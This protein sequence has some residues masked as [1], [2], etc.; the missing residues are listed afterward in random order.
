MEDE[1]L[2]EGA[3][4]GV[5]AAVGDPYTTYMDKKAYDDFMAQTHG[6]YG[7]IGVVVSVDSEDN[8]ITVVAPFEGSPGEK[9][10]IKPG[11]KIIKVDGKE[12]WGDKYEEAVNMMRGP[13]GTEVTITIIREGITNPMDITIKRDDI[14]LQTVKHKV[15]NGDIGYIRISM[16][17]EKT[18]KDFDNALDELYKKNIKGLI[19][20]LRDNPGGVLNVVAKI[21][22]RLVPEGLIVYTEDKNKQRNALY[23]DKEEIDIPMAILVNGGSASASEILAG[24][25]KDHGKGILVG[26]RTYGKGLV[27]TLFPLSDGS[28]VKVT[29]SK[30]FTPNGTSIQGVGIEPDIVIDLPE[31]LK[32]SIWE[33][34]EEEDVQLQK[35]IEVVKEQVLNYAGQ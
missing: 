32:G 13:K 31:E 34:S 8:L 30:Y 26:T 35:A 27:Q 2:M 12:V 28:A 1:Q 22:D 29:I 19:I 16:F 10:G 23:S 18:A 3:V 33:L 6:S 5:A 17:D 21:T 4:A 7:G 9:A 20:D 14:V 24:A 15:L 25:V 11:D